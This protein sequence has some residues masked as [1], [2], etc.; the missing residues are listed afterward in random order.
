[1]RHTNYAP[2]FWLVDINSDLQNW[3]HW[4]WYCHNLGVNLS[5]FTKEPYL[6]LI[7][8]RE[9]GLDARA[10]KTLGK[11]VSW[12]SVAL[13]ASV[14]VLCNYVMK[15]GMSP[16]EWFLDRRLATPAKIQGAHS[17]HITYP[18]ICQ[19]A[20]HSLLKYQVFPLKRPILYSSIP[21]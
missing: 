16:V 11:R 4:T 18:K 6:F 17:Y 15:H 10:T 19:R 14:W 21:P 1:M 5:F 9:V 20:C 12:R 7:Y 2:L 3:I 8:T 13:I